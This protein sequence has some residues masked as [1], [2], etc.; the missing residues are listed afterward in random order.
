MA[1]AINQPS[2]RDDLHPRADARHAG[3]DPHKTEIAVVKG[4]EDSAERRGLD[5]VGCGHSSGLY[6]RTRQAQQESDARQK[7]TVPFFFRPII[8]PPPWRLWYGVARHVICRR[9]FRYMRKPQFGPNPKVLSD[10]RRRPDG[11][12]MPFWAAHNKEQQAEL[13]AL[14]PR[15]VSAEAGYWLRGLNV[16]T[17]ASVTEQTPAGSTR[18]TASSS[19]QNPRRPVWLIVIG[20]AATV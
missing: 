6:L 16:R 11:K 8:A 17:P 2:L 10:S 15:L 7:R 19:A 4:L 9:F 12:T 1:Q 14:F 20:T 3:T 18:T 13:A 5:L